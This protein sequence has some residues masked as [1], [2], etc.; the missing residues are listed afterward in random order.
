MKKKRTLAAILAALMLASS[1]TA[2]ANANDPEQSGEGQ[3]YW[4]ANEDETALTDNLPDDLYYDDDE[5]T[6][7]SRYK[8]GWTSGEIAVEGLKGEPVNDAVFERNKAVEERLGIKIISI[9]DNTDSH[10]AVVAKVANSVKG[11][12]KDYDIMAAPCYTTLPE[13]LSGTFI[14]LRSDACEYL[15]LDQPWWT[16]G[17]HE[18]VEYQGAQY[19]TLGSM[20]LSMYRF[21]F[22]T[23]FNKNIFQNIEQPLLY[24]YV[25]NGTWTL[26][27]QAQLVPL[28][29]KDD[30]NGKQDPT[31]D[32][33]GFVSDSY[34]NIDA[35]WSAC[36]LNIVKKD[37]DGNLQLVLDMERLHGTVEKIIHLFY[38]TDNATYDVPAT[39]DDAIWL[40][41]RQIFA[42]GYA[43]MASFRFLEMEN[44]VMRNME[45]EY[46]VVPMP[47]YDVN[48]DGYYTLLHDQFTV[49]AIPAT[50]TGDRL[51]QMSAVLEAMGSAS[52]KIVR[53]V[54]Y[55]E[56]LRTKIAQDPTASE[57][58]DIITDNVYIDA[59]I[60]YISSLGSYHHA[61]RSVVKSRT[62]NSVSLFKSKNMACERML[63][64]LA[65]KLDKLVARE[66]N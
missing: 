26:D 18:A 30:G 42:D 64:Q 32:V 15:E 47:K 51:T 53:P 21:G 36:Q 2:C 43:A 19:A 31:G 5:V 46:G 9:E 58:M 50:V 59:G 3:T 6:I 29:H 38:N 57:M 25:Q 33:Y 54:Y 11:G 39:E 20:V 56:N 24:E 10:S 8:E 65:K 40:T 61:L 35:Y 48:Q 23:V 27:K 55:E 45:Q 49:I 37:G 4:S 41:I 14:N 28:F 12:N 7:I 22:V 44:S 17:F 34:T 62:N 63:D 52:Y 1:L 16:Q 66:K 60:L 13:T